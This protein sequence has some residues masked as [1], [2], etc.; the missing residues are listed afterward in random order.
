MRRARLP[1]LTA[2]GEVIHKNAELM[3]CVLLAPTDL[4][5]C[6]VNADLTKRLR[7]VQEELMATKG[8]LLRAK[9]NAFQLEIQIAGLQ[10]ALRKEQERTGTT[11]TA[12]GDVEALRRTLDAIV[13]QAQH[14]RDLVAADAHRSTTPISPPPV[15]RPPSAPV[16]PE[17]IAAAVAALGPR[18]ERRATLVTPPEL[19]HISEGGAVD[20]VASEPSPSSRL[21]DSPA[22]VATHA[23]L[24]PSPIAVARS[25]VAD[26]RARRRESGLQ[27][28]PPPPIELS[29][30]VEE[31]RSST[32]PA[33]PSPPPP[34]AV[35]ADVE[36]ILPPPS[37]RPPVARTVRSQLAL[38]MIQSPHW[39][40]PST[41]KTRARRS[42]SVPELPRVAAMQ[43]RSVSPVEAA[44]RPSS[45]AS[46]RPTITIRPDEPVV[47]RTSTTRTEPARPSSAEIEEPT[48]RPARV[49]RALADVTDAA[50]RAPRRTGSIA[51][52]PAAKRAGVKPEPIVEL[53]PIV[54][55]VEAPSDDSDAAGAPQSR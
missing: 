50:N 44:P 19:S 12:V 21:L 35:I 6:R 14:A 27:P 9:G 4:T 46:R 39:P 20:E 45:R 42:L 37:S 15:A 40:A 26:R 34:P 24:A 36:P 48:P 55:E 41:A 17:A 18:R 23:E 30:A 10:S 31:P 2:A 5:L 25:H 22:F 29:A 8:E 54:A 32:P 13:L 3:K 1:N 7:N 49:T 38:G 52:V 47:P 33:S 43:P 28:P 51:P 53:A 11:T 16:E